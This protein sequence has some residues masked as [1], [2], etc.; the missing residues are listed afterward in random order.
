MNWLFQYRVRLY[1]RNS[2]WILPTLSIVVALVAARE[3]I[4]L[5]TAMGWRGT[6]SPETARLIMSTVAASTFTLVVLVSS[7]MLLAVQLAS[8]QLTPRIISLIYRSP[9]G[10]VAFAVF[11]F[12]FTFSIATLIRIEQTVPLIASYVAGYGFLAS[13]ALFIF[14]TDTIGK[15]LRPSS[16]LRNVG[17]AGREVIRDVYPTLLTLD[18]KTPEPL[19]ILRTTEHRAVPSARDGAVLAFDMSG[20]VRR[21]TKFDCVIE[22]VPQVGDFIARG[23]SIFRVYGDAVGLND[24]E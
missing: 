9:Y 21:A 5:E 22:M 14:F 20:L 17:L 2:L 4:A 7:A 19:K 16:A 15:T 10:K 1:V 8:A 23:D 24:R 11:V 12:T 18:S 6:V 13:L 3:V